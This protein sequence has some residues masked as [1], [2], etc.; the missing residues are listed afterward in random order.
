MSASPAFTADQ[1]DALLSAFNR[2]DVD[3]VMVHF[4][5]AAV[6]VAAAGKGGNGHAIEGAAAI[7]GFFAQ[8]FANVPDL[9][10]SP[11][12]SFIC[13]NRAATEWRVQSAAA[14]IDALGCDLWT[15][16]GGKVLVKDT[17]LKQAAA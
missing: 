11:V 10:W 4:A 5:D 1:L 17:Y 2:H 16:A 15:F 13:G 9:R 8:R 6:M 7:R 12:S 3:G 14:G